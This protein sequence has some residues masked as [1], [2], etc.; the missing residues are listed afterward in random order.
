MTLATYVRCWAANR[1]LLLALFPDPYAPLQMALVVWTAWSPSTWLLFVSHA[2]A[3][4]ST[5]RRM[6]FV[7][8]SDNWCALM[9]LAVAASALRAL[10]GGPKALSTAAPI[11]RWQLACLYI[12]AGIWKMNTSHL[13][14]RTSCSTVLMLQLIAELPERLTPSWLVFAVGWS[15]GFLTVLVECGTGLLLFCEGGWA[16]SGVALSLALHAAIALTP[17]P[18]NAI[19]FPAKLM[20]RFYFF[21]SEPL[22]RRVAPESTVALA[23]VAALVAAAVAL[24][25]HNDGGELG[26]VMSHDWFVPY[27]ALQAAIAARALSK[28]GSHFPRAPPLDINAFL[29]RALTFFYCFGL[30]ALGLVEM[31]T[32]A[33]PF[34]NLRLHGGSNHLFLPVG[35][36]GDRGGVVRVDATNSSRLSALYPFETSNQFSSR[37]IGLM[38]AVGHAGREFM[39]QL[40]RVGCTPIGFADATWTSYTVPALELRRLVTEMKVWAHEEQQALA[41]SY[42]R[43]PSVRLDSRKARDLEGTTVDITIGATGDVDVCHV[44]EPGGTVEPCASDELALLPELGWWAM[45]V[46]HYPMPLPEGEEEELACTT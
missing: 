10:L 5:V 1:L 17:T 24:C 42:T 35:V 4:V 45:H 16:K 9:D 22:S 40:A 34:S 29:L 18:N 36:L 44:K 31:G 27:F 14:P 37:A 20:P 43:L 7:V 11:V 15:A 6:P 2:D 28:P 13:C 30:L 23:G 33:G 46:L 39:P 19:M 12:S 8:T 32:P 38:R 25:L 3:V 41:M 21:L 26:G